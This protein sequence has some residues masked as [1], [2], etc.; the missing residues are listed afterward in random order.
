[1]NYWIHYIFKDKKLALKMAIPGL[2][3]LL[4]IDFLSWMFS[5]PGYFNLWPLKIT[6]ALGIPLLI[7]YIYMNFHTLNK[8]KKVE[9]EAPVF[10][11]KRE[12]EIREIIKNDPEFA[13][14][15]YDCTYFNDEL[16]SCRRDRL[17]ERVKDISAGPRKYCLYWVK[18]TAVPPS[19]E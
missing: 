3:F 16:R 11:K 12:A 4:L 7:R 14:F 13:T 6:I 19:E 5:P 18:R 8:Q 9:R 1:M 17:Y 2:G 10:E 15:C